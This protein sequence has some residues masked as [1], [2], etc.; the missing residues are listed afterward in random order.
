MTVEQDSESFPGTTEAEDAAIEVIGIGK[1]F[2]A[3]R[4]VLADIGFTLASGEFIDLVS[5]R[6]RKVLV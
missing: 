5:A 6:L 4:P 3:G 2:Q 1:S